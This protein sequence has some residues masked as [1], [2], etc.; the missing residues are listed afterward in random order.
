M[1]FGK[2]RGTL[3]SKP[4]LLPGRHV[5]NAAMALAC[6]GSA[7]RVSAG[8]APAGLW[9]LLAITGIACVLGAHLVLAIGGGDMPV[10]VSMLNSYSGWAAAAAGSC[11][12]TICSSSPARSSAAAAPS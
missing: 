6:V 1:A 10:V 2:L 11:C 3:G 7:R 8:A 9:A 4:L 5:I 12:R